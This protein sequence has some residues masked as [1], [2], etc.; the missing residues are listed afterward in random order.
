MDL[1]AR[2]HV[3]CKALSLLVCT[4]MSH[5]GNNSSTNWSTDAQWNGFIT[6]SVSYNPPW[7]FES[8]PGSGCFC[9]LS[10]A[11]L[12]VVG[13]KLGIRFALFPLTPP[14]T[15]FT[16]QD[17]ISYDGAPAELLAGKVN[18]SICP[19]A[20]TWARAR[21]FQLITGFLT[22]DYN[23]AVHERW[24]LDSAVTDRSLITTL[25]RTALIDT[26]PGLILSATGVFV[27]FFSLRMSREVGNSDATRSRFMGLRKLVAHLKTANAITSILSI[28]EILTFTFFSQVDVKRPRFAGAQ[29]AVLQWFLYSYFVICLMNAHVSSSLMGLTL[30]PPFHTLNG[31]AKSDFDPL[32]MGTTASVDF[33]NTST[34]RPLIPRTRQYDAK[35]S[36][37]VFIAY[38]A[39]LSAHER[40]AIISN[41]V[42]ETPQFQKAGFVSAVESF[43]RSFVALYQFPRGAEVGVKVTSVVTHM[44]ENG[45]LHHIVNTHLRLLYSAHGM[46]FLTKSQPS[47]KGNAS[48]R[49]EAL[50]STVYTVGVLLFIAALLLIIEIKLSKRLLRCNAVSCLMV[51]PA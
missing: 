15:K 46:S 47:R 9:G 19:L 24:L 32:V 25:F 50:L 2:L 13:H 35:T 20:I 7:N 42:L 41:S 33:M 37:D 6:A 45:N 27:A 4:N 22:R 48:I 30:T 26:W 31:F 10:V 39:N 28:T 3:R 34:L 44:A 5:P 11:L 14:L 17:N 23:I 1:N 8:P 12:A 36:Q 40:I 38:A 43:S 16:T 21:D 18:M 49:M 29:L 51:P